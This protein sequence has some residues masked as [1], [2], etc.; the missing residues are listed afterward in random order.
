V[1][2]DKLITMA[3]TSIFVITEMGDRFRTYCLATQANSAFY[4]QWDEKRVPTKKQRQRSAA[5]KVTAGL[6][7][8]R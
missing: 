7:L 8:S 4:R 6:T 3:P 5:G 2:F 1:R